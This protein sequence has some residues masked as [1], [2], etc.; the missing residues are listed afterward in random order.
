MTVLLVPGQGSQYK[1]MGKHLFSQY[2][3]LVE[4]A[5]E[6][7]SYDIQE[8]CTSDLINNTVYA[9]PLIYCISAMA[10]YSFDK[11]KVQALLGHSLGEY[12]ALYAAG[13][14]DFLTGLRI[15]NYRAE[16]MNNA[17][18]GAMAAIIGVETAEIE[19]FIKRH[20]L[21]VY[22][23][24]YNSPEQ[25]V[26]SGA[27]EA[28]EQASQLFTKGYFIKLRVSGAFHS[29]L[30]QACADRFHVYLQQ[31]NFKMPNLPI[32]LNATAKPYDEHTD[33]GKTLSQQL[34]QP[35]Y[36]YQSL[37]Y[38]KKQGFDQFVELEPGTVLTSIGWKSKEVSVHSMSSS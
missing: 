23:A 33:I 4:S 36:W 38:C 26:I 17:E 37:A 22:I 25:T 12:A 3:G 29:P 9:Q 7:L 18:E 34:V 6:L 30:M 19:G 15:V 14:F 16:L 31:F 24:N 8:L 32:I 13:V 20:Q 1:G 5:N 2:P 27:Q 28:I 35:V 10:W 11:T 21:P